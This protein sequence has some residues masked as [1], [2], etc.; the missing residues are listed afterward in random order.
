MNEPGV[1]GASPRER[2]PFVSVCVPV[3][4]AHRPPNIATLAASVPA[5]LGELDGEVV[6][7]LNGISAKLAG[8]PDCA[9]V[10]DLG[11]NR[12]V[13]PG[14]N[15]AAKVTRG[16]VLVFANDDVVLGAG[17]LQRLA[18]ALVEHPE[19][20]VVGPLGARFDF[21]KL[22]HSEWVDPG[23]DSPGMVRRCD[24]VSG[25]LFAT[26][27]EVYERAVGFDEAY[28]PCTSEELDF[29]TEVRVVQGL[30]CYVVAGVEHQHEFHIS[31]ARPWRRLSHNGRKEMLWRI[32]RRNVRHF[33]GKWA[34]RL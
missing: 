10:V 14:W 13:A 21:A 32:H 4:R 26:R 30:Q 20:G 9:M 11:V 18:Q 24:A 6:V 25:F 8:V 31:S 19:A 17:A 34:G 3:Y 7:A 5:A 22:R 16:E 12:G 1:L 29:C 15:A 33:R 28:A 23:D 27:R 2:A